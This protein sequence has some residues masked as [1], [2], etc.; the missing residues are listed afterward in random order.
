[1]PAVLEF[2]TQELELGVAA[3]L[4]KAEANVLP[5]FLL[6]LSQKPAPPTSTRNP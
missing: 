2:C 1:M 5:G 6:K 3:T 4:G